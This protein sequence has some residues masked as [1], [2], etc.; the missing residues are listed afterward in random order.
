MN[1]KT[2]SKYAGTR[3]AC[4]PALR[5]YKRALVT[6]TSD[7]DWS[8]RVCSHHNP[9]GSRPIRNPAYDVFGF[10]LLGDRDTTQIRSNNPSTDDA[11]R[12]LLRVS[13]LQAHRTQ[14]KAARQRILQLPHYAWR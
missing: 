8:V 2:K 1:S 11:V 9:L 10:R 7:Q 13:L 4:S 12:I 5:R 3:L 6:F 14:L